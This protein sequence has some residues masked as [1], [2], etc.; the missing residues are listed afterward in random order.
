MNKKYKKAFQV[1]H[2]VAVNESFIAMLGFQF[3]DNTDE[4]AG[5]WYKVGS[6]KQFKIQQ[7]ESTV[8]IHEHTPIN[9]MYFSVLFFVH[10]IKESFIFGL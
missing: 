7:L 8:K 9:N 2:L 6:L 1:Q 5:G 4:Q 10:H 3:Y